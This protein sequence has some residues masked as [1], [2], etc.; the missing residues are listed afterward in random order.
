MIF[1]DT[2]APFSAA[3][4]IPDFTVSANQP[5]PQTVTGWS[6]RRAAII[7]DIAAHPECNLLFIG[8]SITELFFDGLGST[9]WNNSYV[10]STRKGHNGGISGD[11]SEG[12][13]YRIQQGDFN[14]ITALKMI[15]LL[16]GTNNLGG[17]G[18]GSVIC[19]V[20]QTRDG[21]LSCAKA[22]RNLY[23]STPLLIMAIF[24]RD[25]A[26]SYIR[27]AIETTNSILASHPFIDGTNVKLMNFE[28]SWFTM[29][30][31]NLNPS[32]VQVDNV[33]PTAAG[34]QLW[35]DQIE[36]TLVGAGL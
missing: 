31:Q 25:V 26:G 7:A 24:P 17:N 3:P 10:T 16:I 19:S 18:A 1:A 2:S 30:T 6:T 36:S 4:L 12:V 28:S 27:G 14:G 23:P 13:L 11:V 22:L 32:L 33:H 21:I 29:S 15:V 20:Y 8:D 5:W 35:H 9:I 34:Y